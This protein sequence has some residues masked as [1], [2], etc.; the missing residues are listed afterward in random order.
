MTSTN[1]RKFLFH[2]QLIAYRG[3]KKNKILILNVSLI[4]IRL[5]SKFVPESVVFEFYKRKKKSLVMEVNH[6]IKAFGFKDPSSTNN[7]DIFNRV[8]AFLS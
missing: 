4:T 2:K 7:N 8:K 1:K 6:K 3:E 5:K